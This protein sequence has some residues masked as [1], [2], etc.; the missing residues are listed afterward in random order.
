MLHNLWY[1]NKIYWYQFI[2]IS[3]EHWLTL[4]HFGISFYLWHILFIKFYLFFLKH[5]LNYKLE[6]LVLPTTVFYYLTRKSSQILQILQH[7][8]HNIKKIL[9]DPH[10]EI[11]NRKYWLHRFQQK[12]LLF[13]WDGNDVL[14]QNG[15]K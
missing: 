4:R 14:V 9:I 3:K 11:S 15:G 13:L 7:T 6:K 8:L 2:Y 5:I 1:R 12:L 10:V